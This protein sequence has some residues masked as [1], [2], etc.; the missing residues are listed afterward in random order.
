MLCKMIR[1]LTKYFLYEW[2]CKS[3]VFVPRGARR[4]F[5]KKGGGGLENDSYIFPVFNILPAVNSLRRPLSH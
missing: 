5:K 2:H 1:K 3:I 4:Y